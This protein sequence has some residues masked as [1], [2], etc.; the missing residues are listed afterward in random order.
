MVLDILTTAL[1]ILL[2]AFLI[3]FLDRFFPGL[4]PVFRKS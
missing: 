1:G 2:A 4:V 3:F